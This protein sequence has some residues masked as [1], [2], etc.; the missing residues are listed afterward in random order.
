MLFSESSKPK[1][2]PSPVYTPIFLKTLEGELIPSQPLT[3]LTADLA[4]SFAFCTTAS[5]ISPIPLMNPS[6]TAL[7]EAQKSVTAPP[8]KNSTTLSMIVVIKFN[9]E[10]RR[11]VKFSSIAFERPSIKLISKSKP[12]WAMSSIFSL[13]PRM[14]PKTISIPASTIGCMLLAMASKIPVRRASTL[15]IIVG[16]CSSINVRTD[17]NNDANNPRIPF[18]SVNTC[19]IAAISAAKAP[20]PA[21]ATALR[22]AAIIPK[23]VPARIRAAPIERAAAPTISKD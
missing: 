15:S 9:T 11:S 12:A 17:S 18:S 1:A 23:P 14:S 13:I 5:I 20:T 22:P 21:A 8:V 2:K 6:I 16:R 3:V 7:P 19:L 4:M 10:F